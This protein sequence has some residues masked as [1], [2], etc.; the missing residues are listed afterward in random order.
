MFK[1]STENYNR[2]SNMN[3]NN[4][5]NKHNNFFQKSVRMKP[6]LKLAKKNEWLVWINMYKPPIISLFSTHQK[7]ARSI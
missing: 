4:I 2:K 7:S 3:F 5:I 6:T 1:F